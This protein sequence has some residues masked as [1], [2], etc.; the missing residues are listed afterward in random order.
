MKLHGKQEQGFQGRSCTAHLYA[1]KVTGRDAQRGKQAETTGSD[2]SRA[3]FCCESYG[4]L[5][6][7]SSNVILELYELYY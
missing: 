4:T 2:V 6:F 1:E 7:M 3:F 5:Y